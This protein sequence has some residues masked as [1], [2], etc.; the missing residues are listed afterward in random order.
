MSNIVNKL[1]FVDRMVTFSE[2]PDEITV[3]VNI[4]NCP[5]KCKDCHSKYLWDDVGTELDEDTFNAIIQENDGITCV[6]F[7]GGDRFPE[8]I[9]TLAKYIRDNYP[10]LKIGWYSGQ[11]AINKAVLESISNF[12]YI[13]VGPYIEEFEPLNKQTTN[14]TMYKVLYDKK[15]EYKML[16]DIT[17]K[18]WKNNDKKGY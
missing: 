2:I 6:C 15:G 10:S 4:S 17:Y 14:Q 1:K 18:F 5:I 12:D 11:E 16:E 7:M 9:V 13:K 8:F 3:C